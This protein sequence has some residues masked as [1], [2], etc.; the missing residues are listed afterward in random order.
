MAAT[1]AALAAPA[2]AARLT[3]P[4]ERAFD[5]YVAEV[6]AR[7]AKDRTASV[8]YL[9]DPVNGGSW[10]VP[11]GRLHH[12][13]AAALVPGATTEDMLALLRDHDHHA[14]FY[15]PE[16][17]SSGV[18][19]NGGNS[20]TVAM[21]F[22]KHRIVT[23]VL[24]AEFESRSGLLE[25]GRRGFSFSRSTHLW[26]VDR[27]GSPEERRR[28]EG[29]DD[30]FLWRLNSYWSFEQTAGGL[31]MECEAVS[32]TRDVP[33]GLGWLIIPI[34]RTLPRDSLQFTMAATRNALVARRPEHD[35]AN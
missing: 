13:R 25:G 19:R 29:E 30:G 3:Q 7:L 28:P 35:R 5:S 8:P 16:V 6:E 9:V 33:A 12:W 1:L 34:I 11:G 23:V 20:A 31:R 32:L 21:R 2:P 22:Q 26:Q 15:A 17:V 14:R 27:P 10:S 4:A 24:D 18:L